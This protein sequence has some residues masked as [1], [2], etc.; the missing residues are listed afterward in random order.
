VAT[1][2]DDSCGPVAG[3]VQTGGEST[4]N[5]VGILTFHINQSGKIAL[6]VEHGPPP[7][8]GYRND[9]LSSLD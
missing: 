3:C 5:L 8:Q 1:Q 9:V 6:G 4:Q 2:L 7:F